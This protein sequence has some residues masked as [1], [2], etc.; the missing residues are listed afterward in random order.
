MAS[1]NLLHQFVLPHLAQISKAINIGS[2]ETLEIFHKETRADEVW[3]QL[4]ET[5]CLKWRDLQ[6][7]DSLEIIINWLLQIVDASDASYSPTIIEPGLASE[8]SKRA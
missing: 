6:K 7:T 8:A 4:M 3:L 1:V 2:L 5:K